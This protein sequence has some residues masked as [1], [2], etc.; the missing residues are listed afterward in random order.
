MIGIDL[1][2]DFLLEGE[3]FPRLSRRGFVQRNNAWG[4]KVL[5]NGSYYILYDTQI[6]ILYAR[7]STEIVLFTF[8]NAM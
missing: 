6:Y 2:E 4:W 3:F 5:T 1:W 8:E 7:A